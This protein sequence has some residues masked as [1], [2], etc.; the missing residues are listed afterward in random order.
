MNSDQ[1]RLND[2]LD[3]IKEVDYI[4]PPRIR[5]AIFIAKKLTSE[6]QKKAVPQDWNWTS[7]S[8]DLV[9]DLE[10]KL[11][12]A[13]SEDLRQREEENKEVFEKYQKLQED[14]RKRNELKI[15]LDNTQ[16]EIV[17][18]RKIKIASKATV[19]KQWALF[20]ITH[21]DNLESILKK[22]ILSPNNADNLGIEIRKI[23]DESIVNTRKGKFVGGKNLA[24]FAHVF[25]N[26]KNAML[27]SV[28]EEEK[29]Q[30]K[31]ILSQV[32]KGRIG[33]QRLSVELNEMLA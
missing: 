25:F 3:A 10:C 15:I 19:K 32:I 24:D 20:F 13:I 14:R 1:V 31:K 9:K 8:H 12:V 2:I 33:Q 6:D 29:K 21:V 26:P 23:G 18:I 28:L 4:D 7:D 16:E 11:K 17:K 30:L 5:N 22:G 27:Y